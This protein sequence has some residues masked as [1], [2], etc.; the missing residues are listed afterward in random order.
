MRDKMKPVIIEDARGG[1][2]MDLKNKFIKKP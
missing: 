1:L 2:F